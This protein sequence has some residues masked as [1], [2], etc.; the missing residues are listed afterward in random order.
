M[1]RSVFGSP[2]CGA[3]LVSPS[4]PR[5]RRLTRTELATGGLMSDLGG[6][7]TQPPRSDINGQGLYRVELDR[8]DV[9]RCNPE[10][11]RRSVRIDAP[12]SGCARRVEPEGSGAGFT[13]IAVEPREGGA[14]V[15]VARMG[16]RARA[17]GV[18]VLCQADVKRVVAAALRCG[19]AGGGV[20]VRN[21]S[22]VAGVVRNPEDD[23]LGKSQPQRAEV[24]GDGVRETGEALAPCDVE[25]VTSLVADALRVVGRRSI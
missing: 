8:R 5:V 16:I 14:P 25:P 24:E 19:M 22:V 3:A 21:R 9:P 10:G 20:T 11:W 23:V 4:R 1:I 6:G 2:R 17:E 18:G 7:R 12:A 15:H 13:A